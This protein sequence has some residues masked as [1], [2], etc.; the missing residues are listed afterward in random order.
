MDS[1]FSRIDRNE[2]RPALYREHPFIYLDLCARP[3]ANDVRN[4]LEEAFR[5]YPENESA[6]LKNRIKGANIIHSESAIYELIL[7]ELL[8]RMGFNLKVHPELKNNSNRPDF[9]VTSAEG[10]AFYLEAINVHELEDDQ[11]ILENQKN[12]LYNEINKC[13]KNVNATL[14]L[15]VI[16]KSKNSFTKKDLFNEIKA[17]LNEIESPGL[18]RILW[19]WESKNKDWRIELQLYKLS[20]CPKRFISCIYPSMTKIVDVP[21]VIKKAFKKKATKYGVQEYP[22]VLAI[23]IESLILDDI[24][25]VEGLFGKEQFIFTSEGVEFAGRQKNGAWIGPQGPIHTRVSGAW[26]FH[27]LSA[28][29]LDRRHLLYLN[30]Y[31]SLTLNENFYSLLPFAKAVSGKLQ[32]NSGKKIFELLGIQWTWLNN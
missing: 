3:E 2:L 22:L 28:W 27:N 19:T 32:Y 30:P 1:L 21:S 12:S 15:C 24:D 29:K 16:K 9:L 5:N 26:L 25:E 7:H 18:A 13:F 8:I 11:D 4:F 20:K 14:S 10:L 17:K 31:S 23:N 6:E